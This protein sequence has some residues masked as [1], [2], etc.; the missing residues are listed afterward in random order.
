MVW[1][2]PWDSEKVRRLRDEAAR[3]LHDQYGIALSKGLTPVPPHEAQRD[4]T[5]TWDAMVTAREALVGDPT[6]DTVLREELARAENA[7]RYQEEPARDV[8]FILFVASAR[9]KWL[10]REEIEDTVRAG[11]WQPGDRWDALATVN[12]IEREGEQGDTV[13]RL[14]LPKSGASCGCR[15]VVTPESL[16]P[17]VPGTW[18]V[19]PV[20]GGS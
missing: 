1:P 19:S 17:G 13:F 6:R 10:T 18:T 5:E 14:P 12:W 11:A 15:S 2:M 9:A 16:S 7:H 20:D 3:Q 4:S 8:A